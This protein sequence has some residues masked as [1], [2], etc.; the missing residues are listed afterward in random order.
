[1]IITIEKM[2]SANRLNRHFK[3][4]IFKIFVTRGERRKQDDPEFTY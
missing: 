2:V 4:F 3:K 1:M